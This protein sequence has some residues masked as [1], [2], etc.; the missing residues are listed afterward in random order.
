MVM[1]VFDATLTVR[2][3]MLPIMMVMIVRDVEMRRSARVQV[4]GGQHLKGTDQCH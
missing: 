1:M 4:N 3:H 2:M